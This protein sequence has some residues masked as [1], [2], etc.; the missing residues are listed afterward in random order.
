[1][2]GAEDGKE[3]SKIAKAAGKLVESGFE[4][5]NARVDLDKAVVK[6]SEACQGCGRGLLR[7]AKAGTDLTLALLTNL[8]GRT[9]GKLSAAMVRALALTQTADLAVTAKIDGTM[10]GNA[11]GR[12]KAT[13]GSLY[14]ILHE[15]IYPKLV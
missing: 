9:N 12:S 3:G 8:D 7:A 14:S 2:D 13:I 6:G 15:A 5:L 4:S 10:V 1:M 11:Y